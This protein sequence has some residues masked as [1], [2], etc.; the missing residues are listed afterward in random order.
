MKSPE[1]NEIWVSQVGNTFMVV[2][3]ALP[4]LHDSL[5]NNPPSQGMLWFDHVK[6]QFVV[7]TLETQFDRPATFEEICEF[8]NLL[9]TYG[10]QVGNV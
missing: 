7:C 2:R 10:K 1:P 9:A 8:Y 4:G 3:L 6:D 5:N